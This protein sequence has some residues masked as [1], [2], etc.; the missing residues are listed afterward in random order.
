MSGKWVFSAL[1]VTL[2]WGAG[3]AGADLA[4]GLGNYWP[5][6]EGKGI[7]AHDVV[8]HHDGTLT[9]FQFDLKD[10]WRPGSHPS[11]AANLRDSSI[12]FDGT[13]DYVNLGSYAIPRTASIS[14]WVNIHGFTGPNANNAFYILGAETSNYGT[15]TFVQNDGSVWLAERDAKGSFNSLH[16]AAGIVPADNRWHQIVY[17]RDGNSPVASPLPSTLDS[18]YVDGIK[19]AQGIGHLTLNNPL[20][21]GAIGMGYPILGPIMP[22]VPPPAY[23]NGLIDDVRVYSRLLTTSSV[24]VDQSCDGEVAALYTT[25]PLL[26]DANLDGTVDGTDLNTVLSSYNQT[27]ANW[28][29]GDFN[30]DGTVDGADLNAVLSSYNQ[31]GGTSAGAAVPEPSTLLLAAVGLSGLLAYARRKRT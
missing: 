19:R 23:A 8:S 20:A 5:F 1:L 25:A 15:T 7:I 24:A 2:A 13:D 31:S 12:L 16:T 29:V 22:P 30:G 27:D 14:A 6:D 17:L 21:P 4:V 26:G 11:P 3:A 28:L 9:S 10:G 18:I